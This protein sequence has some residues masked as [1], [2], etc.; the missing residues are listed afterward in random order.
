M[1]SFSRYKTIYAFLMAVS[2]M[3]IALSNYSS[4]PCSSASVVIFAWPG[5]SWTLVFVFS[6]SSLFC[7]Y[8]EGGLGANF[9]GSPMDD[10]SHF[11][12]F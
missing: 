10:I 6:T 5:L 7:S 3:F 11:L 9:Q 8:D 4:A 12:A 2:C 1:L